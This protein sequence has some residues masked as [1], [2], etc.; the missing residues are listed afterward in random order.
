MANDMKSGIGYLIPA[1]GVI[2]FVIALILGEFLASILITVM[3]ILVWFLYMLV[4]E[5]T[6]PKQMGNM[7]MLFGVMLSV[8]IFLGFGISQ[9]LWG[10]FE[11]KP[12]GSLLSLVILFF[13]VLTGLNFRNQQLVLRS[14]TPNTDSL[15]EDDRKFVLSAIDKVKNSNQSNQATDPKVIVVKQETPSKKEELDKKEEISPTNPYDP[16]LMA[17]NPY[18]SYPPEYY[19]E[20]EDDDEWDD[21]DDEYEDDDYEYDNR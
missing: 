20:Y 4:M 7:I 8:G 16:Y 6:I 9:N 2:G 14:S 3:G 18:F 21:Y 11:F 10:G 5:S 13:A 17:N 1:S 12:E 15:S 19:D